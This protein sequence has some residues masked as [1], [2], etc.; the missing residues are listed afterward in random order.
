MPHTAGSGILDPWTM[1]HPKVWKAP[2]EDPLVKLWPIMGF[3]HVKV[4]VAQGPGEFNKKNL[5]C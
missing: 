5:A 1:D 4:L 2:K 3:P